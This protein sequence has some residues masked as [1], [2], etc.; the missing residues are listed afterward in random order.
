MNWLRRLLAWL[1]PARTDYE[2]LLEEPVE[3]RP[4]SAPSDALHAL[5]SEEAERVTFEDGTDPLDYESFLD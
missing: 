1:R 3:Y 4:E 2:V 5:I